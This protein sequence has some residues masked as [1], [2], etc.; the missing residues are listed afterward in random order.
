MDTLKIGGREFV[1]RPLDNGAQEIAHVGGGEMSEREW[2]AY[3]L[4][5]KSKAF[6]HKVGAD[7]YRSL[8]WCLRGNEQQSCEGLLPACWFAVNND[9]W[10]VV[11][12]DADGCRYRIHPQ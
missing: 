11:F 2:E 4:F 6:C 12:V 1:E 10:R 3:C 9:G 7:E 8:F 5:V